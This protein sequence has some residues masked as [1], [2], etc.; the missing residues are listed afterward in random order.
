[1]LYLLRVEAFSPSRMT[2]HFPLFDTQI[3][4]LAAPIP[5]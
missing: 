4:H 3:L 1:M 5:W 2:H